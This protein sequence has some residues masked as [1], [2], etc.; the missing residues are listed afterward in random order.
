MILKRHWCTSC[1]AI[2][3]ADKNLT[4]AY[5][6][7]CGDRIDFSEVKYTNELLNESI[8]V[9]A[10]AATRTESY[11]KTLIEHLMNK[12]VYSASLYAAVN[13]FNKSDYI[14]AEHILQNV[15][16]DVK[17]EEN[18]KEIKDVIRC[19]TLLVCI[20]YKNPTLERIIEIMAIIEKT[21]QLFSKYVKNPYGEEI[22]VPVRLCNLIKGNLSIKYR[23]E[24]RAKEAAEL[25]AKRAASAVSCGSSSPSVVYSPET[26]SISSGAHDELDKLT[27]LMGWLPEVSDV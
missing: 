20:K 22:Y 9:I 6:H 2:I 4:A 21:E 3:E 1:G 14:E 26:S 16:N 10:A 12:G 23:D 5:C 15:Y 11:N 25:E 18:P 8:D 19:L 27:E 24:L 7:K 13:C 17:D